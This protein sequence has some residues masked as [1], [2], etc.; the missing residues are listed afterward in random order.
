[1]LAEL[2]PDRRRITRSVA[3]RIFSSAAVAL[4][5]FGS[6]ITVP[7]GNVGAAPPLNTK[8]GLVADPVLVML[9][10]E[11]EVCGL[12][13]ESSAARGLWTRAPSEATSEQLV[14]TNVQ[15]WTARSYKV[16][17][18]TAGGTPKDFEVEVGILVISEQKLYSSESLIPGGAG[19]PLR[20]LFF[21][22]ATTLVVA[23]AHDAD[24]SKLFGDRASSG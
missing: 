10:D 19:C 6:G 7:M 24:C 11:A 9:L 23:H 13:L 12:S 3:I 1:M 21:V 18:A 2:I 14:F 8:R 17:F 22:N 5:S 15:V 20:Q 16:C 4:D